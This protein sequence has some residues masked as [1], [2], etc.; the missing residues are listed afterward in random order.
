MLELENRNSCIYTNASVEKA[1]VT[2]VNVIECS[3]RNSYMGI[4]INSY[5]SVIHGNAI[6]GFVML[7]FCMEL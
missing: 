3:V 4:N 7:L 5:T 1:T 6:D 2:T